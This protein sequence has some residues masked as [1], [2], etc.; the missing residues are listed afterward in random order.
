LEA[1]VKVDIYISRKISRCAGCGF[2]I[3]AGGRYGEV[4]DH[5]WLFDI[6]NFPTNDW[7]FKVFHNE[8]NP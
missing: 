3:L 7:F 5:D 8:D 2:P 4:F 1:V 6:L